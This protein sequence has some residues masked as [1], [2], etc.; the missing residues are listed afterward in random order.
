MRLYRKHARSRLGESRRKAKL[1][2]QRILEDIDRDRQQLE[3]HC[4]AREISEDEEDDEEP[5]LH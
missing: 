4:L 2:Y 1:F 5:T 3:Q